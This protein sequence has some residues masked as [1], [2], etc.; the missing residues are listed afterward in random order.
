V[1]F[2]VDLTVQAA[3]GVETS[4]SRNASASKNANGDSEVA[5]AT[6]A[7]PSESEDVAT[8]VGFLQGLLDQNGSVKNVSAA[9]ATH[10]LTTLAEMVLTV[11]ILKNTGVGRT[12]NK[13]RKHAT[14]SVAKAATQLVAKWKK[15]LL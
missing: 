14:P 5:A 13:L 1:E 9:L 11:D 3:P 6:A 4:A 2:L 8:R 12:I 15:D 10:V 7:A